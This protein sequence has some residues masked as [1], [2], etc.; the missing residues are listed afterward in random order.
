MMLRHTFRAVLVAAALASLSACQSNPP[1]QQLPE[2][3]FAN[4]RPFQLDVGQVE[5]VNEFK[6]PAVPQHIESQVPVSPEKAAIRWAQDRL[7]PVGTTGAV[8]YTIKDASVVERSLKT[9]KSFTGLF[10]EEQEA[11]YDSTLN[12]VIT[13]LDDR[14]YTAATVEAK[15]GR[16]QTVPEGMKLSERDRLWYGMVEALMADINGQLEQLLPQYAGQFVR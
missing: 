16:S 3:T 11:R 8:R 5:L 13:F 2:M 1:P 12:V 6:P 10:K 15:A 7:R 14:G 9:D 4:L